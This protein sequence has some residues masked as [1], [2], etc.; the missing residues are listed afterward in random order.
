[1]NNQLDA[2]PA[3]SRLR[4]CIPFVAAGFSLALLLSL[5]FHVGQGY[6]FTD[7][8]FYL[9]WFAYT[10]DYE[11]TLT[12]FG[13]FY[14]PLFRLFQQQIFLVRAFNLISLFTAGFL[15]VRTCILVTY[16]QWLKKACGVLAPSL[17]AFSGAC[18]ALLMTRLLVTPS[19]NHLAF[20]GTE[21]VAA[22]LLYS[23][24][25]PV[26]CRRPIL[27]RAYCALFTLGFSL[28]CLAK[29][30]SAVLLVCLVVLLVLAGWNS[31]WSRPLLTD[32]IAGLIVT[33]FALVL[34]V[35]SPGEIYLLVSNGKS[36]A[37]LLGAGYA[38]LQLIKNSLE[39]ILLT[40]P[41]RLVA[42]MVVLQLA[43]SQCVW[44]LSNRRLRLFVC[45]FSF[46]LALLAAINVWRLSSFSLYDSSFNNN[47]LLWLPVLAVFS[48]IGSLLFGVGSGSFVPSFGRYRLVALFL[49]LLPFCFAFGTG[50][51]IFHHSLN[52]SLFFAMSAVVSL[53]APDSTASSPRFPI[54]LLIGLA[55]SLLPVAS[56]VATTV[57]R[58]YRQSVPLGQ[59]LKSVCIHSCATQL[60]L[61]DQSADYVNQMRTA[62]FHEGFRLD[63]PLLDFTGRSPGLVYAVGGQAVGSPWILG[64]YSGSDRVAASV[65]NRIPERVLRRA[66]ILVEPD[67]N[68][69]AISASVLSSAGIAIGDPS[70]YRLVV[71]VAAPPEA[72]GAAEPRIQRL[73]RPLLP[74]G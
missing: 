36:Q 38:P 59:N 25:Q 7:E 65:L 49:I 5:L 73:Y 11:A 47:A 44:R 54:F 4:H 62:A 67:N 52:A 69:Q 15:A 10:G 48:L 72:A 45:L 34:L 46:L 70:R 31:G 2:I 35:G 74:S 61:S 14:Q 63:T 68:S 21:L 32:L 18:M 51:N 22:G 37:F 24:L 71:T 27:N 50:N 66:W 16:E 41:W 6:D 1:M 43:F 30:S 40:P 57:E 26:L 55:I 42:W 29:P 19:Y 12:F 13:H 39:A 33:A 23:C 9:N 17:F 53:Y 56:V 8:G 3:H 28:V 64:G 60:R 58:P 20:L